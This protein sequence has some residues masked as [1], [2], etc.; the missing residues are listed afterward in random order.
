AQTYACVH[1]N[2]RYGVPRQ[3]VSDLVSTANGCLVFSTPVGGPG[4]SNGRP[5]IVFVTRPN[6]LFWIRRSFANRDDP[7]QVP[8]LCRASRHPV[9]DASA[10][11]SESRLITS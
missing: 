6:A 2:P 9:I 11:I 5:K 10:R 7:R 4:K 3:L 1:A 8:L